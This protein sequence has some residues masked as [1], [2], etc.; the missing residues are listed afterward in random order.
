M[1]AIRTSPRRYAADGPDE[2]RFARRKDASLSAVRIDRRDRTVRVIGSGGR[3][4]RRAAPR[5]RNGTMHQ[6]QTPEVAPAGSRAA[7]TAGSPAARAGRFGR[8][9][10]RC[11]SVRGDARRHPRPLTD[12]L[13]LVDADHVV[14]VC[15]RRAIE[16][17]GLPPELMARRPHFVEVLE[18]QWA[19][20]EFQPH[21]GRD[22]GVR[23]QRRR[24]RSIV[25][26]RANAAGRS[27]DRGRQR[28]DEG[29]RRPAYVRRHHRAAPRRRAHPAPGA[30]RRPHEPARIASRSTSCSRRTS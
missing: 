5:T 13:M 7:A 19:T 2:G 14:E 23:P 12:G 26:L 28:R 17:L 10:S 6:I 4:R 9:R 27:R 1:R 25:A 20:D 8:S 21:A 18:Y 24:P 15:N 29:R 30:A 3:A 11:A 16:L 22:Q